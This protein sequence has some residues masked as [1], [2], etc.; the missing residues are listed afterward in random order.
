ME[1]H[2]V[3]TRLPVHEVLTS[4]VRTAAPSCGHSGNWGL[5]WVIT[6]LVSQNYMGSSWNGLDKN[7][8]GARRSMAHL[9]TE[10]TY[11]DPHFN[12]FY[13][14]LLCAAS[15]FADSETTAISVHLRKR[16]LFVTK[17]VGVFL[18]PTVTFSSLW[19]LPWGQKSDAGP[20]VNPC[21][22]PISVHFKHYQA[23]GGMCVL[24]NM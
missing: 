4:T 2:P 5:A 24:R 13:C 1:L 17:T 15:G 23:L 6:S 10:E 18:H 7:K 20:Q 21:F 3:N 8:Y 16:C 22:L 19:F 12:G 14:K 11:A 9:V